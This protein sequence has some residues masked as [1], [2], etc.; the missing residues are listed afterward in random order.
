M[1]QAATESKPPEDVQPS[2]SER[3]DPPKKQEELRTACD[4]LSRLAK[5][6]PEEVAQI[7]DVDDDRAT[8][9]VCCEI[10]SKL[11]QTMS[12]QGY[13][14]LA[15]VAEYVANWA[16]SKMADNEPQ[17][18]REAALRRMSKVY[19]EL[20]DV[21]WDWTHDK[22]AFWECSAFDRILGTLKANGINC[23]ADT[24]E[25][26]GRWKEAETRARNARATVEAIQPF[27]GKQDDTLGQPP[28]ERGQPPTAVQANADE[29]S[30]QADVAQPSCR[31]RN[32]RNEIKLLA[33]TV[34]TLSELLYSRAKT[35]KPSAG[36]QQEAMSTAGMLAGV[37]DRLR[38]LHGAIEHER[39]ELIR[40]ERIKWDEWDASR[41][42]DG[43]EAPRTVASYFTGVMKGAM[44]QWG[45]ELL[46]LVA[47]RSYECMGDATEFVRNWK[48]EQSAT[49]G[50]GDRAPIVPMADIRERVRR[51]GGL[52]E[53]AYLCEGSITHGSG[54][55]DAIEDYFTAI[56]GTISV[57]A[58]ECRRMLDDL[59]GK[60]GAS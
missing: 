8:G 3:G 11:N 33:D 9:D 21:A 48:P 2:A 43:A 13:A 60:G 41:A 27:M 32:I 51:I 26:V 12:K 34:H 35:T 58:S 19:P 24:C 38:G 5:R 16:P 23:L 40:L 14:C 50:G 7:L 4:G 17:E 55:K 15:D 57:A 45:G 30:E 20:L 56:S 53:A 46:A 31:L 49:G 59:D 44:T 36:V 54:D 18:I 10:Y 1:T 28:K 22:I 25:F 6:F 29:D 52:V 37:R 42:G 47:D 39:R